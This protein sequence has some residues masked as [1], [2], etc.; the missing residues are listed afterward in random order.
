MSKEVIYTGKILN[1]RDAIQLAIEMTKEDP[2]YNYR[3]P[4]IDEINLIKNKPSYYMHYNQRIYRAIIFINQIHQLVKNKK[5]EYDYI[6]TYGEDIAL[7][8]NVKNEAIFIKEKH[9]F[10]ISLKFFKNK[11]KLFTINNI[12]LGKDF[13]NVDDK[14]FIFIKN[15]SSMIYEDST[16]SLYMDNGLKYSFYLPKY[17]NNERPYI[18]NQIK[19][20]KNKMNTIQEF[21]L[22]DKIVY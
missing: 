9:T 22:N 8:D 2:I 17:S 4:S 10:S 21:I 14:V 16:L 11:N 20:L 15:V 19:D 5:Y 7:P 3:L 6:Y 1:R 12:V 18:F 13:I